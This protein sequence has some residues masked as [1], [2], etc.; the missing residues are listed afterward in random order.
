MTPPPSLQALIDTVVQDAGTEDP[1][2]QLSAAAATAADLE[3]TTDALLG[4]FVDRCRRN[5]RSWSDI[6]AA[7]GVTKQ[8][9]H[10][11]F[12]G[13]I[14]ERLGAAIE[15]P[16]FERFTQRARAALAAA[17]GAARASGHRELG[18][19]H[20]LLGL[21]AEPEGVA[22]KALLAMHVGQDQVQSAL[23]RAWADA[24]TARDEPARP[25][26]ADDTSSA[27]TAGTDAATQT[28]ATGTP[29]G[30]KPAAAAAEPGAAA[31]PGFRPP[32]SPPARSVLLNAVAV[33]LE[34]GHNYIGTEHILLGL[35][36][37]PDSLAARVLSA[38]GA[39]GSEVRVRIR[40]LLNG[41]GKP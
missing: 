18:T 16:T 23:E 32:M 37:D 10:K 36:R 34:F 8:A 4:H 3:E 19:G 1:I 22:A 7:L 29:A 13:P 17:A 41:F 6:S 35:Y 11:R 14:A 27:G 30:G 20:L 21:Y 25:A 28:P 38:A 24:V 9:V 2:G 15:R 40:E 26:S 33:A 12:A 39:D 5:G 31:D